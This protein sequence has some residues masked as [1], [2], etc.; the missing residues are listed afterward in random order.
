MKF[1]SLPFYKKFSNHW[2]SADGMLRMMSESPTKHKTQNKLP[3]TWAHTRILPVF[4]SAIPT[5]SMFKV[6]YRVI[7]MQKMTKI[8][9]GS[10]NYKP[11]LNQSGGKNKAH[12]NMCHGLYIKG[13]SNGF[14]RVYQ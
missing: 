7:R 12:F 11:L 5:A 13:E 14:V 10:L 8:E 2:V 3:A 4:Y 9:K 1:Y 6:M